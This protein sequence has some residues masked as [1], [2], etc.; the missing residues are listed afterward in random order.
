MRYAYFPAS[1]RLAVQEGGRMR[2]Y[3]TGSHQI[4]GVSQQQGPGQSL[5]FSSNQGTVR[6]TDL[7]PVDAAAETAP[8]PPARPGPTGSAVPAAALPP[9]AD[10]QAGGDPLAIIERLA[11]LQRKGILTEEE[12]AAKKAELLGR[13]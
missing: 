5:T 7:R 9:A 4:F 3:D 1:R 11:E 8:P 2:L 6:V 10:A 13:L 12:F